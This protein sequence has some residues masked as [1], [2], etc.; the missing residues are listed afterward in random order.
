MDLEI[1]EGL[2]LS[3]DRAQALGQLLPGSEDHDY[4]RCLHAQHRGA[5]DE[6]A[7]I[8]D[9]WTERHGHTDRYER[10]RQR[11]LW[12]RLDK[13]VDDV[14]EE[15]RDQFGVDHSHEAE[16][17]ELDPTR[18]TKLAPGMFDGAKL[19]AEAVD[20]DTNL[21]QVT[22]EG[23]LEL[24]VT[25]LSSSRRRAL[26][27]RIGHTPRPELVEHVAADLDIR[28]FGNLTAHQ[29]MTLDQL[30]ALA[31]R[32]PELRTHRVWIEL[33]LRR[34]QPPVTVDLELDLAAREAYVGELWGFV[35]PLPPA[36]NTLK[37]HVL[38]HLLDTLRRRNVTPEV[39]HIAQYLQL[40]RSAGYLPH[41]WIE[42]IRGEEIA[43]LG[44]D[45]RNVTGLPPAGDDEQ[46]VR[47]MLRRRLA[48]AESFAQWL[49]R[50]WLD[51]EIA[52]AQLLAGVGDQDKATRVLGPSAAAALRERVE[53][54][55]CAHNPKRFAVDETILLEA[56]VK[57]VP[58]LL[59][60][61][62]RIDPLA[63]FQHNRRE[64]NTDLDLDGL[65]ASHEQTMQF[66]EAPVRRVRRRIELPMCARPGTYVIDLIGNGIASRALVTKGRLRYVSRVGAAGVLVTI[67]DEAGRVRPDARAW[68][69]DRE[70]TP[71]EH[72]TFV[73][74][75]STSPG[76]Q[77]MLLSCGDVATVAY[78]QLVSETYNLD[79][80]LALDRHALTDG[81]TAKA[82]A[83]LRLT[84]AGAPAS[85]SLLEQPQWHVTLTDRQGVATTKSF[86]LALTDDS[87]AVLEMPIG[88]ATSHVNVSVTAKIK[89]ISQQRDQDLA[90]Q[91]Y[92]AVAAMH[93]TT[94][95]E[96]LYLARTSA[97]WVLS[98][99]GKTGEPRAQRPITVSLVH[100]WARTELDVELATDSSGRCEL[101]EL[102]GIAKISATLGD[103]T[104]NWEL[105][106]QPRQLTIHARDV[107]VALPA[108][109]DAADVIAR[110][111]L[112]ELRGNAPAR[113]PRVMIE[114]A[115]S[116]FKG[117]AA[118][119]SGGLIIR[120]LAPGDYWLRAPGI[121]ATIRV[122][123]AGIDVE[124]SVMTEAEVV[125]LSRREPVI[126]DVSVGDELVVRV[127]PATRTR[128]H[129]IATRFIGAPAAAKSLVPAQAQFRFDRPRGAA[130]VSGRELGDEYRYVLERR[131]A[132][133]FPSVIA[134]KPSLLLNPWAR[135]TTSTAVAHATAGRAFAASSPAPAQAA[136]YQSEGGG[137][138]VEDGEAYVGYD[139]VPDRPVLLANL[140]PENGI[141]RVPLA[142][143]G[144]ATC[145]T[146][147]ADDPIGGV[148]TRQAFLR[149]TALD[150]K[151]L[152]LRLALDS[153]RHTTQ[154]KKIA[155]LLPGQPLVI[156]DLATAK[157][158]LLDTVEK[159]HAYLLALR[160]DATLR[161]FSFVTRWHKIED[162]E[163]R[164][165]YSKY[166][167]HELHLFLYFRDRTFFDAVVKPY[168]AHK[169]TK[170]FV[171]HWL[172]DAD[173]RAYLEPVKLESLNAV[174]RAL[175]AVRMRA[176][177]E[178]ARLLADEVLLIPPDP[179]RDTRLIDALLGASALD[180][181]DQMK[182][183]KAD[184]LSLAEASIAPPA[185]LARGGFGG[186][187]G[188]PMAPPPPRS[189][190]QAAAKPKLAKK[191]AMNKLEAALDDE[192]MAD[193]DMEMER[194]DVDRRR[195]AAPMFRAQ[196]KT[197][198]WAENN[199]W[200]LTPAESSAEL[201][202]PNRLWRD[203]ATHET[204]AF[205][206]PSLGLATTNF[207]EAM[208][209][210]AVTDLPFA[211][212]SHSYF[213]EGPRLTITAAG[214]AL[215]GTSQLVDGELVPSGAPLVVGQ[216]YVRTDDRHQWV[217]GE[218]VDKYVEGS[219]LA[220][221]VYTCQ[222]V[223][224]NPS[225]SRQRIAALVQIP[226]GSMPLAGARPTDTLDVVLDPYGTHGHEYAFYFPA[227]G[228]YTHFPVHVSRGGT[229]V[230]AAQP[231]HLIVTA[232]AEQLDPNS[233]PHISQR[234][235][236]ADVVAY[237]ARANLA[238]VELERVAW[239]LDDRA[240]YDAILGA[241]EKRRAYD[242]TLWGYA[243]L[244]HDV[245]RIRI[246]ARTLGDRLLTAGPVLEMLGLDGEMLGSY[247]HL[248]YSPLT[249]ARAHR[250]G[251]KV[252]ILNDGLTAQYTRFLE[253][254][255]HRPQPT[256]EDV[257]A[258]AMYLLAQDR[259]EAALAALAR[260][261]AT[262]IADKLQHDYLA[263]Y[264]AC[265]TGDVRRAKE[266]VTRWR[267][268]PVDRWRR[269][270][271]A[272]G[273]MLAE[274]D[275]AAPAIVD[276]RNREQQQ[277]ELAA[278]QP[279]FDIAVDR[280]GVVIRHQHVAALELRF[281]EM[282]VELLFSRQPFVQSD[283]SRFSFIEPGV[284]ET[285]TGIPVEH[286]V[287]W[288]AALRG[289]N[290]VVEAVGAGQRKAKIHYANDL[291]ANVAQQYGQVRV[292][293]ASDHGGLSATYVKVYA[294]H[295]G[296]AVEFYKDGYTDLRGWFDY[297]TLSTNDLDRVERFA[298]LVVSDQAGSAI[299]EAGPPMR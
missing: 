132:K 112:V 122:P 115:S 143:L 157:V 43:Q 58:E 116:L 147:I 246:W 118:T 248:E 88:E 261:D 52:T 67:L 75:F 98:A 108:D 293:R 259:N 79:L 181:D 158:H 129:V 195:E 82:I 5:L 180:G 53:L 106:E 135:R 268:L 243:L 188:A 264:A 51:V 100:R 162:A 169:R 65:A 298:I 219:F 38:W 117:G 27:G 104:Q 130:Y 172:L 284:R 165:L 50:T 209:A 151:D 194:R 56:D 114:P 153:E 212:P 91:A 66:T 77:P 185:E 232:D 236:V 62:F 34:M 121:A 242:E 224:A 119:S 48:E 201:I 249:N 2:A 128:V 260:V 63:Y 10:L 59:V 215:V 291:A 57:H 177:P 199:W 221:V 133:R 125:E 198:E 28:Y 275:G 54:A 281:F 164:E 292:Q 156:A 279:T 42:R 90:Q 217:D 170:T 202:A 94:D 152:R 29:Q 78:I 159:A 192:E 84:V 25:D 233:W 131:T 278:K 101:G 44:A 205:L 225:S 99:L 271:E 145:V 266:L 163:R 288:P 254:V 173:L 69:G 178:L 252:R 21:S 35:A 228:E 175:L 285:L 263:A 226:R 40:P 55:W 142:E 32:K 290:V 191:R 214:N 189:A 239:R 113:H 39:T 124:T 8:L 277:S 73:V 70:Y 204:G 24:L 238:E 286:R 72:G 258:F 241:L 11:Q 123:R 267:E 168:L 289:K 155:P 136:Y 36:M 161:E 150:P 237:L 89:V 85:L 220:G 218:Q 47:D 17:P 280:E 120:G 141:V 234:G 257:L 282:D 105:W 296:G 149:E 256:A 171:D 3:P 7:K 154:Q 13:E 269:K 276:P 76:S 229:I 97:G 16:V 46:L 138:A 287:P 60:K 93:A 203:F 251:P 64:V 92:V 68:L 127:V 272:V 166:A 255:A 110:S 294:R 270:F 139:F 20:Y 245:P 210:L 274:L 253:L 174:E 96:A 95:I 18:P 216:S 19:L 6:A 193:M 207:A 4:F 107:V 144:R 30:H 211:L 283:V 299:L 23:L 134:D 81:A 146:V 295:R 15:L 230:A 71:D 160:D 187:M 74:P 9:V 12:Y 111:S 273:A 86:P 244:H 41:K 196:D 265:V 250:L 83:R 235:S 140:V 14:A 33:V 190:P 227:P 176:E 184:A 208:C 80:D 126:A 87:A 102:P 197:Q 49:E 37:A 22:D 206:S 222:I 186:P 61:V 167:C 297:A 183:F 45:F 137:G 231:R 148:H 240:A 213:A 223:L 109:R 247:E 1:L 200:H 103:Q 182:G 31:A 26:L 179:A 262:A